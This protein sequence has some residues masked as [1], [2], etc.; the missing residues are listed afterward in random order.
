MGRKYPQVDDGDKT[1]ISLKE[2]E[3]FWVACCD[4]GL[5]H[6]HE[7]SLKNNG[8]TLV[9]T[10]SLA[11]RSTGQLRRHSK[12]KYIKNLKNILRKLSGRRQVV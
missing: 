3:P 2:K 12:N 6:K 5:T 9:V 11:G 8:K 10:I 1:E 7:Y 4:C